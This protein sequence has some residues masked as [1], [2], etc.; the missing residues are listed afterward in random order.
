[1]S[2]FL[3]HILDDGGVNPALP[4]VWRVFFLL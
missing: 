1:V 3:V 4:N 2:L